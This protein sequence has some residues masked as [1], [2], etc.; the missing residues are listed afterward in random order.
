MTDRTQIDKSLRVN[1]A[2]S[3]STGRVRTNNEDRFLV[4]LERGIFLVVDGVGG[5]LGGEVA[6]DLA[7]TTIRERVERRDLPPTSLVREAITLANERILDHAHRNPEY[8]GMACVLT[9]ALLDD[10]DVTIGHV[11]D[12]RLYTLAPMGI[13]K[14]T[15]DHSPVG[16]REDLQQISETDAMHDARRNEVYRDVGS[17]RQRPAAVDFVEV[18]QTRLDERM[19]LVLC[20]DGLSDLVTAIEINRIVRAQ[21]GDPPRVVAALID[22]ANAAGGKD[23]ITVV[24]AEAEAFARSRSIA[25]VLPTPALQ[26]PDVA[27]TPLILDSA[28]VLASPTAPAAVA[29]SSAEPLTPVRRHG[30][31]R[32]VWGAATGSRTV[33]AAAG[34]IAGI[35]TSLALSS[36][37]I[38][39]L[40]AGP[41]HLVVGGP[42][43]THFTSIGAAL[44][45][46]R[47]GDIIT[48]EPGDY[49]ESLVMPPGVSIEASVPG[50]VALLPPA[51]ATKW[52]AVEVRGGHG[53][54]RGVRITGTAAQPVNVGV[55]IQD[56]D[57]EI[58]D[59]A[60]EGAM[61]TGVEVTGIN[62][63]ATIRASRFSSVSGVGVRVDQHANVV[64]RS[65]VFISAGG[66]TPAVSI[67]SGGIARPD[68]N[69]F[70][71]FSR[72]F[73]TPPAEYLQ[74]NIVIPVAA[75]ERRP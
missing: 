65:N 57:F 74:H 32:R 20:S 28:P 58:D 37:S 14:I 43:P 13:T 3:T 5:H 75:Q 69:L 27:T 45:R 61:A 73:D 41:A 50:G 6:A 59:V 2:G 70:L 21:A 4:D 29:V 33:A 7:L 52:V 62:A 16:E 25:Q 34:F 23:N 54:L 12:S 8:R 17:E 68:S 51:G 56:A 19:A 26:E 10:R 38:Q 63:R 42:L 48:I 30:W 55:H 35:A 40:L 60:F 46:A 24:Y 9:L 66:N 49:R 53:S 44:Q 36:F 15:H 22:A 18:I 1:A 67:T 71:H 64:L 39:A 11:G 31:L 47:A 72:P